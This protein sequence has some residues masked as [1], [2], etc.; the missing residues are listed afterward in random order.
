MVMS[1]TPTTVSDGQGRA[2][3]H[4]ASAT[5]A[6][7]LAAFLRG[8]YPSY[9]VRLDRLTRLSARIKDRRCATR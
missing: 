7:Q 5:L 4:D 1:L 3:T 9:G 2:P 8:C 6:R